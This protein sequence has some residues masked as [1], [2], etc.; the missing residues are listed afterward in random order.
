MYSQ[1]VAREEGRRLGRR[2][3]D[4]WLSD[5]ELSSAVKQEVLPQV[6]P[7][8]GVRQREAH[9]A[10]DLAAALIFLF[11]LSLA[12]SLTVVI[13]RDAEWMPEPLSMLRTEWWWGITFL[14]LVLAA[15]AGRE[16][17]TAVKRAR[18]QRQQLREQLFRAAYEGAAEVIT[19]RRTRELNARQ[20][21]SARTTFTA[22]RGSSPTGGNS[23]TP[24]QAE[25]LAARW[26]RSLGAREVEVTQFRGDGGVDV[27]SSKYI[28]Q[29]KHF[30]GNV[31]V[32]P[33]RE[34]GGVVRVDGRRGL[35]FTT[36][37]Y[38][39]GAIEFAHQSGIALFRMDHR[40]GQLMAVNE[41]AKALQK[42]GLG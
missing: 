10:A 25:E 16:R 14:L 37:G 24:R 36:S 20:V 34:L 27:T 35:F 2:L 41:V 21:Q 30:T 1:A 28:A 32:A 22:S 4:I 29:V 9:A 6:R 12:V 39:Q 11:F 17:R 15:L 19:A 40:T 8:S 26:M 38:A 42:H 18:T 13:Y 7:R 3:L 5:V 31:G 33:I 23:L